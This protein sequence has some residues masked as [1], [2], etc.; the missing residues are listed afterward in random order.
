MR[1][2]VTAERLGVLKV[3]L[4]CVDR[5]GV[6]TIDSAAISGKRLVLRTSVSEISHM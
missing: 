1:K 3:G 2:G 5:A 4:R 6:Y